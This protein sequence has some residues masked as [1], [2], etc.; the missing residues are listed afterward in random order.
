MHFRL[1]LNALSI[2][3]K[4]T[5][6]HLA[7]VILC[8]KSAATAHRGLFFSQAEVGI[9][10]LTVT[11][12]QTCA[13]PI[14]LAERRT[15]LLEALMQRIRVMPG[16]THAA[17]GNALPFMSA[18]GF[19]AFKM[20][21]SRNPGVQVDAQAIDRKSGVEGKNVDVGGRRVLKKKKS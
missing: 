4:V 18:G 2:P 8:V 13:L 3:H 9:R 15:A 14:Y 16:V 6:R 17:V 21:S 5:F 1:L 12:V 7:R 20:R 11:G 10:D 19:R